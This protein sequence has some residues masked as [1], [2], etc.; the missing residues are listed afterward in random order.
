[1]TARFIA[2]GKVFG[3]SALLSLATLPLAAAEAGQTGWGANPGQ[4]K[5]PMFRPL[6]HEAPRQSGPGLR[7]RPQQQRMISGVG[8]GGRGYPHS[9]PGGTRSLSSATELLAPRPPAAPTRTGVDVRFRPGDREG[10]GSAVAVGGRTFSAPFNDRVHAQFRPRRPG[11]R[12]S[13]EQMHAGQQGGW[14]ARGYGVPVMP[15]PMPVAGL[16]YPWRAW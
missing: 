10:R 15:R 2:L 14:M 9:A 1:M 6:G 13:Y 8:I 3:V 4:G 11:K 5:R 12:R 7:W 16:G